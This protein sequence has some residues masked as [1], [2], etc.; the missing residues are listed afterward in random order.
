MKGMQMADYQ[1]NKEQQR[2][3]AALDNA[4]ERKVPETFNLPTLEQIASQTEAKQYRELLL[5]QVNFL[6]LT[7]NAR[8]VDLQKI[9]C[10]RT[11][12]PLGA[13]DDV[14]YKRYIQMQGLAAA[15]KNLSYLQNAV[16]TMADP[17]WLHTDG[18]G[19]KFLAQND[20]FGYF[21]YAAAKAL[22]Y[23]KLGYNKEKNVWSDMTLQNKFMIEKI[24][25]WEDLQSVPIADIIQA[26]TA[27]QQF[28]S[29]LHTKF[30]KFDYVSL[31]YYGRPDIVANL[32]VKL[33]DVTKQAI[34]TKMQIEAIEKR[35]RFDIASQIKS[36]LGGASNY[37]AQDKLRGYS[38]VDQI[39]DILEAMGFDEP[40]DEMNLTDLS[41]LDNPEI[42]RSYTGMR[43]Q[44]EKKIKYS[45]RIFT[46]ADIAAKQIL[47]VKTGQV[48][49]TAAKP[50]LL[51][52]NLGKMAQ[53]QPSKPAL[54]DMWKNRKK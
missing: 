42:A 11:G 51:L 17:C 52:D 44:S 31:Q 39:V 35:K 53:A 46:Q 41:F 34:K 18:E 36:G 6:A 2:M 54:A 33:A 43:E 26:N 30:A 13:L 16:C 19:L 45:G 14:V 8:P 1:E 27:W 25:L 38:T 47:N 22:A 12:K 49:Y 5:N 24:H 29:V 10:S 9:Y 50:N 20:P 3:K 7:E 21:V 23:H 48:E 40:D 15:E 37:Q 32:H 28:H 4:I